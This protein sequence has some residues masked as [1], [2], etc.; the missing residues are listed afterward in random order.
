[1]VYKMENLHN[2]AREIPYWKNI[3][4]NC[5]ICW[6]KWEPT[7]YRKW[8]DILEI[9][10]WITFLIPWVIYTARRHINSICMCPKCRQLYLLETDWDDKLID[11]LVDIRKKQMARFWII[12]FFFLILWF[13]DIFWSS[14]SKDFNNKQNYWIT[15]SINNQTDY[16]NNNYV[17]N[18]SIKVEKLEN[19]QE[20]L[21]KQLLEKQRKQQREEQ[22]KR[23]EEL[24]RQLAEEQGEKQKKETNIE[25]RKDPNDEVREKMQNILKQIDYQYW[26]DIWL[27]QPS[28]IWAFCSW[29]CINWIVNIEFWENIGWRDFTVKAHQ[30]DWANAIIRDIPWF[31]SQIQIN[32]ICKWH[33]ISSCTFT[34]YQM[35]SYAPKGCT[36]FWYKD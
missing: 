2:T 21:E 4:I 23:D 8:N 24:T 9:I 18:T 13:F 12:V 1:M 32:F 33:T 34:E 19:K 6:F 3:L 29:D 5:P 28:Y 35:N 31:F 30:A 36:Y 14:W 15:N 11:N 27:K 20:D 10:L 7:K 17:N 22:R 16:L 26:E 25:K